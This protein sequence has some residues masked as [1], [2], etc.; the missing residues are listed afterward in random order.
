MK[1]LIELLRDM[2]PAKVSRHQAFMELVRRA[3]K[4]AR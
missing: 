3:Q 2:R 1:R 4:E